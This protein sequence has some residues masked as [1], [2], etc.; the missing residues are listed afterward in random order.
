MAVSEVVGVLFTVGLLVGLT[1]FGRPLARLLA[2][3]ATWLLL[4]LL[5]VLN[6]GVNIANL[7]SSRFLYLPSIA[8]SVIIGAILY[9]AIRAVRPAGS[10]RPRL[11]R[12][13]LVS[14][15]G[16]LLVAGAVFSWVQIR[17]WRTV[18]VQSQ[19]LDAELLRFIPP[20]RRPRPM[21]WFVKNRPH[22][23]YGVD[24]FSLG[25][26]FRRFFN[27]QGDV[28]FVEMVESTSDVP[29]VEQAND[30]FVIRFYHDASEDLFHAD[31][32]SGVTS[33]R[34]PP[35]GLGVGDNLLLW[36]FTQCAPD[37][38]KE[39]VVAQAQTECTPGSGLLFKPLSEDGQMTNTALAYDTDEAG[40]RFV[41]LRVAVQYDSI[42]DT[43]QQASNEASTERSSQ[44]FWTDKGSEW[45]EERFKS[46]RLKKDGEPHVYWSFVPI[47]DTGGL[48]QGLRF[49]PVNAEL[50]ARVQWI[51]VD[52]V[53]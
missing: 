14:G 23:P 43:G 21:W 31:Y 19:V 11:A 51:A 16:L 25:F 39:W 8:Y 46:L 6:L 34:P 17:P 9:S 41:R 10:W 52:L 44:W 47:E 50:N 12:T 5:P 30:A 33:A 49:D 42:E 13:A 29:V 1:L 7:G 40:S 38:L 3:V 18:S 28:P 20:E 45:S 35:S 24:V 2:I 4:T 36:D 48:L 37:V 26:G 53:K 32:I 27:G 15:V 22:F